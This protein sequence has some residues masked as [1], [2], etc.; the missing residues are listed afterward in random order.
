VTGNPSGLPIQDEA[1][2][3]YSGETVWALH[4]TSLAAQV[5]VGCGNEY[6]NFAKIN[7]RGEMGS[8][9]FNVSAYPFV[10]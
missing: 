6:N 2:L 7:V 8:G 9:L 4:P 5:G 1:L 10:P 3:A